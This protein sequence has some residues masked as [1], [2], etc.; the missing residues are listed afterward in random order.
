MFVIVKVESIEML[1]SIFQGVHYNIHLTKNS[2]SNL[3]DDKF[4]WLFF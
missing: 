4:G 2:H 3:S 1:N